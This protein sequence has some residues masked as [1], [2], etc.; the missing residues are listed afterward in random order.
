MA[1]E[2]S[3][4]DRLDAFAELIQQRRLSGGFSQERL[5]HDLELA[6]QAGQ[7]LLEEVEGLKEKL[8]VADAT[9]DQLLDRL[10]A[11]YKANAALEKVRRTVCLISVQALM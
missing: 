10:A 4:G 6:A 3:R 5:E 7:T 11:S 8:G 1:R 2:L 9:R